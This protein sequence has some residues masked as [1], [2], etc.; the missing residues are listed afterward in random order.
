MKKLG[1]L[2]WTVFGYLL[3]IFLFYVTVNFIMSAL[4]EP[5]SGLGI[6]DQRVVFIVGVVTIL[7]L[8]VW[9][10]RKE[11]AKITKTHF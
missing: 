3:I 5:L 4:R 1:G 8:I 11:K 9:Q 2:A 7:G 6:T 10:K